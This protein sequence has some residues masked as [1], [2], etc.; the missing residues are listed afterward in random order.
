MLGSV[1]NSPRGT[2]SLDIVR[3]FVRLRAIL[4]THAEIGR[5]LKERLP[6]HLHRVFS[7]PTREAQ[8]ELRATQ[9][10]RCDCTS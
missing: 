5:R 8:N 1:L 7:C 4:F 10:H 9:S 2:V 6:L 3:V